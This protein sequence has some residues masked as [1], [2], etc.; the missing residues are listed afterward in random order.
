M[1]L[2]TAMEP[3]TNSSITNT[4]EEEDYFDQESSS[5]VETNS[6]AILQLMEGEEAD[7]MA[8]FH[9]ALDGSRA[10]MRTLG[11]EALGRGSSSGVVGPQPLDAVIRP[12]S[13][14][15]VVATRGTNPSEMASPDNY[16]RMYR[17]VFSIEGE[18]A[19][20][21]V[22][23]PEMAVVLLYN[24]AVVY[25]EVGF[26]TLDKAAIEKAQKLYELARSVLSQAREAKRYRLSMN[27]T[28]L[29]LAVLNNLGHTYCFFY[30]Y[31]LTMSL[32][33]SLSDMLEG[34]STDLL[35]AESLDFFKRNIAQA[36]QRNQGT[37]PAA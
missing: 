26:A 3:N 1:D 2:T 19:E 29:E 27:L 7:A 16:F 31:E 11:P 33:A 13:L 23:A 8:L 17:T 5:V 34:V 10:Q 12:I 22:L 4:M 20:L 32:R 36:F 28:E 37:A 14:D 25:Q 9:R 15:G 24:M 21:D 6:W 35:E 18:D 30:N